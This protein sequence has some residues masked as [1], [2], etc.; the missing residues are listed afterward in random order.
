M[1]DEC[2]LERRQLI[3]FRLR[4]GPKWNI[5]DLGCCNEPAAVDG[6]DCDGNCLNDSDGDLVCDEFE[7]AGCTYSTADNFDENATDPDGS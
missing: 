4:W 2:F 5:V 3:L 7:V 1:L 6:Y